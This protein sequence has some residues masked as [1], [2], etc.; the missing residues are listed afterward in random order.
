[1]CSLKPPFDSPNLINLF[2]KIIRA[3]YEVCSVVSL[4]PALFANKVCL[5]VCSAPHDPHEMLILTIIIIDCFC[6]N[7][8]EDQAQ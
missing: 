1:M 5:S 4:S 2:Y 6:A 8:L 7:I 3:E